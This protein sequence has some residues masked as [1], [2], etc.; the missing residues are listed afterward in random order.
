[1]ASRISGRPGERFARH[2]D[3][4]LLGLKLYVFT[5]L[6]RESGISVAVRLP[7]WIPEL[8]EPDLYPT[9][10]VDD[11]DQGARTAPGGQRIR[12]D[13]FD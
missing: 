3:Y 10:T 13:L 6:S 1:M 11:V 2:F 4:R 5:G 12:L 9:G 7:A 8:F